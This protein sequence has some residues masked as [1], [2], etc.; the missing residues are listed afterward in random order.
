MCFGWPQF[1]LDLNCL[2]VFGVITLL[3]VIQGRYGRT[4]PLEGG[5]AYGQCRVES[6]GFEGDWGF[7]ELCIEIYT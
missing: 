5:R 4:R 7:C 3:C 6:K 2:R 1:T